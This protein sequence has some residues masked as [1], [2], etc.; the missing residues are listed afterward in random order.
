[1]KSRGFTLLEAMV[2]LVIISL[3][4]T[5]LMQ[6]LVHVLGIRERVLRNDAEAGQARLHEQWFRESVSAAIGDL[7]GGRGRFAG[8]AEGFRFISLDPLVG[9]PPQPV[10]WRIDEVAGGAS[11]EYQH[12][13]TSW[14]VIPRGLTDARFSYLDAEG[15]WQEAWPPADAALAPSVPRSVRFEAES[16][17]RGIAWW[18]AIP[19]GPGLSPPLQRREDRVDEGF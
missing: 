13:D 10:E 2:T 12:G 15:R 8:D 7:S 18:V 3:I 1:V 4:A 11:L 5:V 17:G 19:S 16:A 9:G 6:S 14:A